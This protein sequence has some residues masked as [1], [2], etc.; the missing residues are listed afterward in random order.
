MTETEDVQKKLLHANEALQ[1]EDVDDA[2]AQIK[3]ALSKVRQLRS[4]AT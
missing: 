4:E 2:E 1:N 3:N